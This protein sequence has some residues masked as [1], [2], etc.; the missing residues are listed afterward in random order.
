MKV[1]SDIKEGVM[2]SIDKIILTFED[3]VEIELNQIINYDIDLDCIEYSSIELTNALVNH[4][5]LN[6]FKAK[7][8]TIKIKLIHIEYNICQIIDGKVNKSY[9]DIPCQMCLRRCRIDGDACGKMF[10]S[11]E[12]GIE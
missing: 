4:D 1:T 7:E 3:N 9:L 2:E 6:R 5:L 11:I 12:G 10:I 8:R